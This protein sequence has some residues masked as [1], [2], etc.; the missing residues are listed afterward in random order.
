MTERDTLMRGH[1][2]FALHDLETIFQ[3]YGKDETIPRFVVLRV[4]MENVRDSIRAA[5][6][7]LPREK[8]ELGEEGG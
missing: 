3:R 2:E 8:R 6:A 5:L 1:L 7:Q 4:E